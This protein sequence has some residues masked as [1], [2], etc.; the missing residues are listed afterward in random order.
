MARKTNLCARV[1][2]SRVRR[3]HHRPIKTHRNRVRSRKKKLD[4]KSSGTAFDDNLYDTRND[5][6]VINYKWTSWIEF[7]NG[8]YQTFL[9]RAQTSSATWDKDTR[10]NKIAQFYPNRSLR[11]YFIF[12][13][14][15]VWRN[16]FSIKA[17]V[18]TLCKA[19]I[20]LTRKKTCYWF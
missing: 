5:A 20:V 14:D 13:S 12:P 10:T 16:L 18:N 1:G 3:F 9:N 8:T 19:I 15:F 2:L 6:L 4:A 11:S 7:V 17:A